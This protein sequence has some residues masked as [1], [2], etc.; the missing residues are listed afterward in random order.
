MQLNN[1]ANAL[2]HI[3]AT[4]YIMIVEMTLSSMH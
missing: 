2:A 1:V 3:R 4:S